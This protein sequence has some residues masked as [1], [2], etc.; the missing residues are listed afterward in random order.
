M[1]LPATKCQNKN[2]VSEC[3]TRSTEEWKS[4]LV[5]SKGQLIDIGPCPALGSFCRCAK[6][7]RPGPP[8]GNQRSLR[9]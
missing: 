8:E 4:D 7:R 3:L 9:G 5:D 1:L 2:C 6:S